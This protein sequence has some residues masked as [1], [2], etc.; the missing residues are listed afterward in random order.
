MIH[1]CLAHTLFLKGWDGAQWVEHL[2][3]MTKLLV[4]SPAPHNPE[5]LYT[6]VFP[7]PESCAKQGG[8]DAHGHPVF[9]KQQQLIR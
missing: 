8:T 2:P 1:H 3:S 4:P 6:P 5:W 9:M 7:A